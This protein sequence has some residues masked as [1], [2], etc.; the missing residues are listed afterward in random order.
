MGKNQLLG[1]EDIPKGIKVFNCVKIRMKDR[2]WD[3]KTLVGM[4]GTQ[5]QLVENLSSMHKTLSL[6]P[7][8]T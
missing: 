3:R 1:E 5:G 6:T 8:T 2:D 7:R 4:D